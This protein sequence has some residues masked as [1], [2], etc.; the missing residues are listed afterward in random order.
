[1]CS[2]L[3]SIFDKTSFMWSNLS[4]ADFGEFPSSRQGALNF[5]CQATL[6]DKGINLHSRQCEPMSFYHGWPIYCVQY[7]QVNSDTHYSVVV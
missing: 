4:P 1:M 3:K 6:W 5:L 2:I 7:I